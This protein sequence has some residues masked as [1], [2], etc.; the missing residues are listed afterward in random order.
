MISND[1]DTQLNTTRTNQH[2]KAIDL[3]ALA[4]Q[5]ENS[6]IGVIGFCCDEGVRRN[7]GRPGAFYGPQSIRHSLTK[8]SL[9]R[10][11][12]PTLY[13]LGNTFCRDRNLESAQQ[14]LATSI[15][16]MLEHR[17]TP[18]VLG[19]GHE[20]SWGHFQ[21]LAKFYFEQ[22]KNITIINLDA[23]TDLRPYSNSLG[24]SG[25]VFRQISELCDEHDRPFSYHCL[26]IQD[27]ALSEELHQF[28]KQ[29]KCTLVKA[30]D[31]FAAHGVANINEQVDRLIEQSELIYLSVCMDV[32]SSAYAPGVSS[33]QVLGLD[34]RQILP[35]IK[36]ISSSQK[37]VAADIVELAPP[38]DFDDH[39]S[40]LAA[41]I[42]R[43]LII[44]LACHH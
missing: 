14:K 4:T 41:N 11:Q 33:P 43:E 6:S 18:I 39:T 1:S 20:T 22:Q 17:V 32:F 2:L 9:D 16:T 42:L 8:L 19:G 21:G 34:P 29:K 27:A 37:I 25:S 13:D 44:G 35:I 7:F 26:G 31:F 3:D 36:K 10:H 40:K 12:L 30:E 23:H 15:Y 24:H 38:F 5:N 28:A